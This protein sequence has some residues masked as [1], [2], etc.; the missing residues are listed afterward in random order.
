MR[1]RGEIKT[2]A[3]YIREFV[4]SHPAYK[5]DSVVSQPIAYDLM[6]SILNMAQDQASVESFL[7]KGIKRY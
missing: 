2:S 7:G 6:G 1:A 5:L 4:R 3:T